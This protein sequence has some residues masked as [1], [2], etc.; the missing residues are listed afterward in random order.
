MTWQ[1]ITNFLETNEKTENF[2]KEVEFIE[3]SQIKIT[4]LKNI[5][6]GIKQQQQQQHLIGWS[7]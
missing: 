4:E 3:R 2:S 5:I 7:P 6:L 1:P